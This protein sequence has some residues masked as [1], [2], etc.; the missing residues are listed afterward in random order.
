MSGHGRRARTYPPGVPAQFLEEL[1]DLRERS[2]KIA[3]LGREGIEASIS[4]LDDAGE[5]RRR[6]LYLMIDVEESFRR[7]KQTM[8][9]G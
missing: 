4:E 8:L 7:I 2:A 9:S 6:V 1:G 5:L 3:A